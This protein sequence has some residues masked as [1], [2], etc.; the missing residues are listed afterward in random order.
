MATTR[1]A[2]TPP[3]IAPEEDDPDESVLAAVDAEGVLDE[4]LPVKLGTL[5]ELLMTV[6]AGLLTMAVLLTAP[7]VGALLLLLLLLLLGEAEAADAVLGED[8]ERRVVVVVRLLSFVG[9][10]FAVVCVAFGLSVV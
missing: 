9:S 2:T 5:V 4:I 1:T 7:L 3:I 6:G 8:E 10:F